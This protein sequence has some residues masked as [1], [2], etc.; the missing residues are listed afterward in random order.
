M[1]RTKAWLENLAGGLPLSCFLRPAAVKFHVS[2][3]RLIA[4]VAT[5]LAVACAG[6]FALADSGGFFNLQALPSALFWVALALLA[7]YLIGRV[8]SD[9]RYA[10]LVPVAIGSN[11]ISVSAVAGP[12]LVSPAQPWF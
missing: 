2:A 8:R 11:G 1:S 3:N 6:S 7:G 10:L 4:L 12:V 9:D 5:D